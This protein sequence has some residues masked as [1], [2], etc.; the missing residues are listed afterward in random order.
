VILSDLNVPVLNAGSWDVIVVGG[1]TAGAIAGISSARA[2]AKTLVV[3]ALGSLGGSGT[4]A[5]VTPLMRNVSSGRNLNRGITEDLKARLIARG[6]GA[7]DM[8]NN[9]NWFNPEGMKFV[10]E[11]MLVEAG[12]EVLYHS[13]FVAPVLEGKR[14]SSIV[15]HNKD[16]LSTLE[17]KCFID[18][19]G[20]ADV[21]VRAGAPFISVHALLDGMGQEI[22][23]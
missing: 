19:T 20:D 23:A 2:G 5:Q 1:G 22:N 14:V 6:D 3:E 12:G 7:V 9:D 13:Q 16:G 17:A 4:N 18:S 15:V 11:R 8:H 21:C 10:L